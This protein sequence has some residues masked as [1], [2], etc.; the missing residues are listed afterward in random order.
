MIDIQDRPVE[1]SEVLAVARQTAQ[2]KPEKPYS[3]AASYTRIVPRAEG[4]NQVRPRTVEMLVDKEMEETPAKQKVT[5]KDKVNAVAKPVGKVMSSKTQSEEEN[6]QGSQRVRSKGVLKMAEG[7]EPF[8]LK[9]QL[10]KWR[11]D[12]SLPQLMEISPS[13]TTEMSNLCKRT[14]N[15]EL[16]EIRLEVPRIT[17]CKIMVKIFDNEFCAVVDTG[18]ACS[19][20]TPSLLDEWGLIA[21]EESDQIIVTADGK[22]HYSLGRVNEV[23]LIIGRYQF[24]V[25]VTIM[26]RSDNTL[27]LGTDWLLEHQAHIDLKSSEMRLPIGNMMLIVPLYTTSGNASEEFETSEVYYMIKAPSIEQTTEEGYEDKRFEEMLE[28][29]V[30]LFAEEIDDLTQTHV[31][32]HRIVLNESTPIKQKPYRIPHH[33]L[34]QVRNE[35]KTMETNG[36]IS[37]CVSEWCSPVVAV[38]KKNEKLRMKRLEYLG[39]VIS[40][41]GISTSPSKI[42]AMMETKEPTS[43][44]ELQAFL[45]LTGYYRKF[46]VG[47]ATTVA[48]LLKLLKKNCV[49]SWTEEC[50][51]AVKELKDKLC[52]APT[53]SHPDWNREFIVTT[54]A[55]VQGVGAILSQQFQE[56]ERPISYVSRITN[57][58]EKNYSVSHLEGLAVIWA[59]SKFKYYLYGKHFVIRKD[60]KSLIQL[61]NS[62]DITGRVARWAMILRNYDYTIV[63]IKGK[64]NPADALSR[65]D[66]QKDKSTEEAI[67]VFAMDYLYY[68]AIKDYLENYNYPSGADEGFRKKLRNKASKYILKDELLYRKSKGVLKEVLHEKNIKESIKKI[69][70]ES[71]LGIEN[72]WRVAAQKYSGEGLYEVVKRV[73]M[74]CLNCQYYKGNREK[75]SKL[76]PIVG[77]EPFEIFGL[78]AVG[79]INPVS[80][81]GNRFILTG[82][83]YLTKWPVAQANFGVPKQIITDRGS[84]FLGDVALKVYEF[85]QIRHTPTTSYRPQSNGQVER[86]NQTLKNVLVKQCMHDKENWD[87]YLWKSLL[88]VRTMRNRVTQLSPAEL[89]YGVKLTTPTIWT[90]PPE[91][92]NFDMAIKERIENIKT[93]IEELRG[94]G[95][96]N[97]IKAKEKAKIIYDK[98]VVEFRFK[99]NDLVMKANEQQLSKLERLWEGPYKVERVLRYGTYVISDNEGNR[100]LVH[101]D[102][103]KAFHYSQFMVPEVSVTLKSKLKRF[104][105]RVS[106]ISGRGSVV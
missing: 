66:G 72:T 28:K 42:S 17:N 96:E 35:L 89:L 106:P 80:A 88:A 56:G 68:S 58:H 77:R 59:V 39:H 98:R 34:Q 104:R 78:D 40:T 43:V 95:L 29:N 76:N 69:H 25:N 61:F 101:G 24:Q 54:D 12:I 23:P 83:D 6:G 7:I 79:P 14:K 73:V 70:E 31:T 55:S 11:P 46:V 16:N 20:A 2:T 63:H 45:G 9:E 102:M 92:D 4:T 86:L 51:G 74:E 33:L 99:V 87:A 71:H 30:D 15:A 22:R 38:W 5:A 13:L 90:P 32:E 103:L 49:W 18:A 85:L 44:K 93:D 105:E 41:E 91:V 100:D 62:K 50:S 82:I 48:P 19:V 97:S 52:E 21:E 3:R 57:Q 64:S 67:D 75:R 81:S 1:R 27:I 8:S 26:E 65:L 94:I 84:G 37:P 53:L 10:A 36:V 60:H 47:Y